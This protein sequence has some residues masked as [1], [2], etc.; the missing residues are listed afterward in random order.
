M[1]MDLAQR[2]SVLGMFGRFSDEARL[3]VV[4]AQDEARRVRRNCI[5]TEHLL[6][7]VLS[8]ETG[9]ARQVLHDLGIDQEAVRAQ[10]MAIVG[11]GQDEPPERIPFT[12]RAVRVF[13]YA[14]QEAARLA[15]AFIGT[16]HLLLGLIEESDGLA[17][18]VLLALG[19]NLDTARRRVGGYPSAEHPEHPPAPRP[20]S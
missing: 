10:A 19:A 2:G 5:S 18:Q 15:D 7:G 1:I 4:H 14:G 8:V 13:E 17:G 12:P 6:L 20:P 11:H 3:A 16:E 9:L